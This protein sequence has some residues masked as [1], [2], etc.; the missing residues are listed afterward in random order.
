M[1]LLTCA[2]LVCALY[3]V[4]AGLPITRLYARCL[5]GDLQLHSVAGFGTDAVLY[6]SKP[7]AKFKEDFEN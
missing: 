4:C 6:L 7:A 2:L 1:R 5:G 3:A